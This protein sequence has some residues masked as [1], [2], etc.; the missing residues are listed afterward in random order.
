MAAP[1][2]CPEVMLRRSAAWSTTKPRDR[3]RNSD[4]GRIAANSAAP[5]KPRLPSRP[6][7]CSVTVST[8]SS[9]SVRVE[10]R[11]A[12]PRASLSAMS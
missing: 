7:T 10:Q 9:S 3:F 5:K 2:M 12:L 11:R 6:S 4:R 1:A 8:D